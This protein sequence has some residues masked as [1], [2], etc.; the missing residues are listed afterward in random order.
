MGRRFFA[1]SDK[2][3]VERR[4]W[5]GCVGIGQLNMKS[6]FTLRLTYWWIYHRTCL[7]LFSHSVCC[8]TFSHSFRKLWAYKFCL[9]L[10][11]HRERTGRAGASSGHSSPLRTLA[12]TFYLFIYILTRKTHPGKQGMK[13]P[14]LITC[15][16]IV[17]SGGDP[18]LGP[19][20]TLGCIRKSHLC[21]GRIGFTWFE[22]E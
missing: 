11:L 13:L 18:R 2:K 14:M 7:K 10:C 5:E 8:Y 15:G 3:K 19:R 6:N 1:I 16:S 4:G 12:S 17:R 9:L 20:R 21:P 22:I